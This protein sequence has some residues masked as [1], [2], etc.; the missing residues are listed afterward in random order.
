LGDA[1]PIE[2]G[3]VFVYIDMTRVYAPEL[4]VWQP[5]DDEHAGYAY[6]VCIGVSDF[7]DWADLESVASY[8]GMTGRWYDETGAKHLEHD[9]RGDNLIDRAMAFQAVGDHSGYVNLGDEGTKH[10]FAEA[11]K[12]YRHAHGT[13]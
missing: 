3:G 7:P 1:S 2:F 6:R 8:I 11:R 4:E 9:L 10:T 12:R 13:R 5:F